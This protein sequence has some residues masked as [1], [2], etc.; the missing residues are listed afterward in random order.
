MYPGNWAFHRRTSSAVMVAA[1]E[2]PARRSGSRTRFLG[3]RMA[4][5]SAMKCTPAKTIVEASLA[6]AMRDR[7]R[8]LS[9]LHQLGWR[10]RID[11]PAPRDQISSRALKEFADQR[12]N[13]LSM[14]RKP[15]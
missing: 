11:L 4:A 9:R 15:A 12:T 2:H 7:R 13:V 6:A 3:E 8:D 10:H 1:S 5:V 14:I